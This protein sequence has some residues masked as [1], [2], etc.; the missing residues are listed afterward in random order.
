VH[1]SSLPPD[2]DNPALL[3]YQA[4][5]LRPEP[6]ADTSESI[7]KVLR[8]GEPDEK[9]KKY[10]KKQASRDTIELAEAAAKLQQCNWGIRYSQG[11]GA[12]LPQLAQFRNLSFLLYVDARILA[13]DGNYKE[14]FNRCLT[15]HRI[16][17]H[18]GDYTIHFYLI[19]LSLDGLTYRCIQDILGSMPPDIDILTWLRE[20]LVVMS[21]DSSSFIQALK[22]D[23]EMCIH[24]FHSNPDSLKRLKEY[25]AEHADDEHTR[26]RILGLTDEEFIA[27]VQ[28]PNIDFIDSISRVIDSEI[29]YQ[30]KISE[31]QSLTKKMDDEYAASKYAGERRTAEHYNIIV[32]NEAQLSALKAAIEIYLIKAQ[33]GQL[34]KVLPDG[35]PKDPFSGKDFKYEIT[36]KGFIFRCRAKDIIA[37]RTFQSPGTEADFVHE[38][39]FELRTQN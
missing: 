21:D 6:D 9:L 12:P 5:L 29:A 3:Y 38:Y 19:S 34:P 4:F 14:A 36:D 18:I 8:G 2:P 22:T 25:L 15:I 39:E 7:H 27:F 1:A 26:E 16:A 11:I 10:L 31:I 33:T 13:A 20:Q 23:D 17:K 28:K 24:S 37:S 32:R 35:L 30:D